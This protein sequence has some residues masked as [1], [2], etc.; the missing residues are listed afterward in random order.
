MSRTNCVL[1]IYRK[2]R[3]YSVR[4]LQRREW[5]N[6]GEH[7]NEFSTSLKRNISVQNNDTTHDYIIVGAGSAGCVLANRLTENEPCNV[8]LMEAGPKDSSWKIWMPAA[9]MYNL[10]DDKYN[11]YYHTEPEPSMNNRVQYWP[12]GRVLGGSSSLNAMVYIR[13][14]AYDYDRWEKEGASNWSYADCLPYFKKSQT[15]ELGENEYRG[16]TGPLHVSRGITNNPLHYA[17]IEAG[18][19]AGYQFTEDMNGYQQEGVGWMDMTIY[20]G[21]RWSAAAAYLHP[22]R[23]K[24][25]NL[26]TKVNVLAT[27]VLIEK[28]RAVG[29]EYEENG[30]LKKVFANKEVVLCGGSINTPQLL[31]LSGVGNADDL[32]KLDIPVVANIPGVGENLQDHLDLCIQYRCTKPVTLYSAQWKFP[33]N[34]IKIGLQ[35]FLFR[36]GWGATTHFESGGFICSKAGVEHPD[37]QIHFLPF[38]STDHGRSNADCHSFM[39]HIGGMRPTSKGYLKLRSRD[40]RDHPKIVANYLT[41]EKDMQEMRDGVKLAREIIHQKAFDEFRGEEMQP[42]AQVQTPSQIDE[43]IRNVADSNYHPACTCKMGQ[44]DDKMAVVDPDTKVIGIENLRVVDASIM[45]SMISGN[46][47]GPTMMVAEKAADIIRGL[48]PLPRSNAPVYKRT[49]IDS[50]R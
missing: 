26:E 20:K 23:N 3:G 33:H 46:L 36:K 44:P 7:K 43:F 12:R 14:H 37:L 40:P 45:P 6:A 27:K 48:Q 19:Q 25:K 49:N 11:W 15:H 39:I 38:A 18:K 47:N 21:M 28:G 16:G 2:T 13:G 31:M 34:M 5:C 35:W 41:T 32:A 42:G 29:V 8:L 10:C 17:F 30:E 50:Q 9:L 22:I 1:Q 24:R 4:L